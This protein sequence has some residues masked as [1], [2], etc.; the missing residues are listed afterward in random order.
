VV[1]SCASLKARV[2]NLRA[3]LTRVKVLLNYKILKALFLFKYY[4]TYN[5]LNLSDATA[6]FQHYN[7][8]ISHVMVVNT[9]AAADECRD[10]TI[11]FGKFSLRLQF[12]P[13]SEI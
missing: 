3:A 1:K 6:A 7:S 11:R 9:V 5:L 8:V 13:S 4:C 12:V 10:Q 2:G